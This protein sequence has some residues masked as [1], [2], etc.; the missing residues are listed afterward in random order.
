MPNLQQNNEIGK[1]SES[2][3]KWV[4]ANRKNASKN[5]TKDKSFPNQKNTRYS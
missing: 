2:I 4:N 1:K 3:S 5:R